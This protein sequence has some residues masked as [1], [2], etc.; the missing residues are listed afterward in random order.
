M[1]LGENGSLVVE[2]SAGGA[3]PRRIRAFPMEAVDTVGAG[4]AFNGALATAL[5]EGRALFEAAVWATAA[6][7]LAVTRPGAQ[8]ALPRRDAIDRLAAKYHPD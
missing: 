2:R 5:A 4:D 3:S 6:A 1:T 7:G 8:P